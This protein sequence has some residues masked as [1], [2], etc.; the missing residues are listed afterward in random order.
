MDASASDNVDLL[1][2]TEKQRYAKVVHQ[3]MCADTRKL[4]S[5]PKDQWYGIPEHEIEEATSLLDT[6]S[7]DIWTD[8]SAALK[9]QAIENRLYQVRRNWIPGARAKENSKPWLRSLHSDLDAVIGAVP[10]SRGDRDDP[11]GGS[12]KPQ[13][14]ELATLINIR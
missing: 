13:D 11:G 14:D 4:W 5:K 8:Q 12:P 9:K 6:K 7:K 10:Q 1:E 2:L 3:E